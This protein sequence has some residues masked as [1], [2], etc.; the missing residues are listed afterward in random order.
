M[1]ES[2][3]ESHALITSGKTKHRE[4]TFRGQEGETDEER[5]E[6]AHSIVLNRG[7][8]PLFHLFASLAFVLRVH[9]DKRT[10]WHESKTWQGLSE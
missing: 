8:I 7:D 10:L 5:G 3:R 1:P 2:E 9:S 6:G 4:G